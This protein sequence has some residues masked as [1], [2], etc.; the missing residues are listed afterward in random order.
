AASQSG[1]RGG[2][3]VSGLTTLLERAV[4]RRANAVAVISDGFRAYMTGLGVDPRRI[5]RVTDWTHPGEPTESA[6]ECR[7]RLGWASDDFICLH[8][9]NM[10]QKQGLDNLLDAA[11]LLNG[12]IR[13]VLS[14]HGNDR[15]RLM[16]R[17]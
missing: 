4:V 14:G 17:T 9:G 8:A 1:Y 11:V 16:N 6:E 10:G 15:S 2:R 12:R 13:I 7:R 5:F 3:L